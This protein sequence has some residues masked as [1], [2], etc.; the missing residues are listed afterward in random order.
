VSIVLL[1]SNRLGHAMRTPA[2]ALG[3]ALARPSEAAVLWSTWTAAGTAAGATAFALTLGVPGGLLVV[4][5]GLLMALPQGLILRRHLH[6]AGWWIVATGGLWPIAALMG[7]EFLYLAGPMGPL[8]GGFAIGAVQWLILAYG[9]GIRGAGWWVAA[10]MVAWALDCWIVLAGASLLLPAD[11]AG[12]PGGDL[13]LLGTAIGAAGGAAYGAV[14][15]AALLWLL[16][17]EAPGRA[18]S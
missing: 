15:G 6:G 17:G 2:D 10:S 13:L 12:V 9:N 16:R 11:L 3:R 1:V 8:A 7:L 5:Y 18:G 14:S 4:M